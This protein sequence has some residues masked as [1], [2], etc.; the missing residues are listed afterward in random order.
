M[1]PQIR[2]NCED[3]VR[4]YLDALNRHDWDALAVTLDP[5]FVSEVPYFGQLKG[6]EANIK[7]EKSLDK[8][9]P[10][11]QNRILSLVAKGDTAAGEFTTSGTL[12][13]SFETPRGTILPT[14]RHFEFR[15]AVFYRVNSVGLLEEKRE[16]VD[17]ANLFK[18]LGLNL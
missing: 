4:K 9:C 8:A 5:N 18:Q 16:Y 7:Y 11:T 17:T 3:A 12:T 10:D 14:G 15:S 1:E 6:K 13:C 2:V